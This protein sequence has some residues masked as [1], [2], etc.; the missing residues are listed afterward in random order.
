MQKRS[1]TS[2]LV[3]N[4]ELKAADTHF[5][6]ETDRPDQRKMLIRLLLEKAKCFGVNPRV[7]SPCDQPVSGQSTREARQLMRIISFSLQPFI[8]TEN[9]IL[10]LLI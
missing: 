3:A 4:L 8:L 7:I 1:R 5:G 6:C 2:V 10:H 9:F